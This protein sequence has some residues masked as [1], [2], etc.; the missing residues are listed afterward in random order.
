M[1]AAIA[2]HTQSRKPQ[3]HP[4]MWHA[5]PP[6][7]ALDI[8]GKLISIICAVAEL[9]ARHRDENRD[10][11]N[12]F[13]LRKESRVGARDDN[14]WACPFE[15]VKGTVTETV[16]ETKI[17]GSRLCEWRATALRGHVVPR[18][19]YSDSPTLREDTP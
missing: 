16:T 6:A 1:S 10:P 13:N 5:P 15:I 7:G 8:E 17:C 3:S 14:Q 9:P 18:A 11:H 19:G 4:L 12:G 2:A